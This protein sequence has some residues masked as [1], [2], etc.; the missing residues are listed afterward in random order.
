MVSTNCCSMPSEGISRSCPPAGSAVRP[1]CTVPVAEQHGGIGSGRRCSRV[2]SSRSSP[3]S[4]PRVRTGGGSTRRATTGWCSSKGDGGLRHVGVTGGAVARW[5]A[6]ARLRPG[7]V[8]R[9]NPGRREIRWVNCALL[10]RRWLGGGLSCIR[11]ARS[12][13]ALGQG[14]EHQLPVHALGQ[15][16]Q[17]GVGQFAQAGLA[18]DAAWYPVPGQPTRTGTA[19]AASR[20][21]PAAGSALRRDCAPC[22]PGPRPGRNRNLAG[23]RPP[24]RAVLPPWPHGGL[25]AGLVPVKAEHHFRAQAVKPLEVGSCWWRCRG[26]RALLMP[27]WARAIT[28]M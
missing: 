24:C 3:T 25:A 17:Q 1:R 11:L 20:W 22:C 14:L 16:P 28:S 19:P 18:I 2:S 23:G 12:R 8:A 13:P 5:L 6:A 21:P 10:R 4:S 26:W 15:L 27:C 7:L 9:G